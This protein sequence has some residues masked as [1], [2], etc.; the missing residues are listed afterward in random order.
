M[1]DLPPELPTPPPPEPPRADS[2]FGS[3]IPLP[4]P[5]F[6]PRERDELPA[7][8][9]GSPGVIW[10]RF[11]ARIIDTLP[12]AILFSAIARH[13]VRFEGDKRIGEVPVWLVI[14]AFLAPL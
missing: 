5:P 4:Y 3:G 10:P 14:I 8:G 11:A 13:Y 6:P 7:V 12:F 9:P 1:S 2:D